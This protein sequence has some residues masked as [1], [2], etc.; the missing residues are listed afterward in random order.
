MCVAA[1]NNSN[2]GGNGGGDASSGQ[3]FVNVSGEPHTSSVIGGSPAATGRDG[4]RGGGHGRDSLGQMIVTMSVVAMAMFVSL[5]FAGGG[6]SARTPGRGASAAESVG[7][8]V[9]VRSLVSGQGWKRLDGDVGG[10]ALCACA[11][12]GAHS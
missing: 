7:G 9:L 12:R 1:T 2:S 5:Q 3:T 6:S 10:G 4:T 11:R 8:I